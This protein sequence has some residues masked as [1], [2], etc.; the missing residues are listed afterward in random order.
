MEEVAYCSITSSELFPDS[1]TMETTAMS[2]TTR[3]A[4]PHIRRCSTLLAVAALS[5]ATAC[6]PDSINAPSVAAKPAAAQHGLLGSVLS[7]LTPVQGITRTTALNAPVSSSVTFTSAGGIIDIPA[8]GLKVTVPAG[9]IP[10][11]SMTI[12]VTALAGSTVAYD[13]QPHGTKFLKPLRME[14]S[15]VGTNMEN[16]LLKP[17]FYGAYFENTSQVNTSAGSATI[18][19]LLSA[20]TFSNTVSF[21]INH[22]SGYMVSTGRS[23]TPSSEME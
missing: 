19:E 2:Q 22:F 7:L 18:N 11:S 23:Q 20:V 8:L 4:L 1:L 16:V 5:V 14:Q 9:A 21:D 17:T 10:T 15:L 12:T 13:F 6:A 3:T